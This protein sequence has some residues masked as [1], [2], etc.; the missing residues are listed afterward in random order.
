MLLYPLGIV[1]CGHLTFSAV[2]TKTDTCV[3]SVDQDKTSRKEPSHQDLNC[4]P[5]SLL[6]LFLDKTPYTVFLELYLHQYMSEFKD[7]LVH[8]RNMEWKG[9]YYAYRKKKTQKNFVPFA[10]NEGSDQPCQGLRCPLTES[11][12]TGDNNWTPPYKTWLRAHADNEGQDQLVHP[13]SL[14]RTFIV[15]LQNHWILQN[16]W[17]ESKGPGNTL[18]MRRIIWIFAFSAC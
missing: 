18:R 11:M 3:N 2:E 15:R 12:D 5:L 1:V 9:K 4:L 10:G 16:I 14:I 7:T 17:M 6:L 8:F 13:H